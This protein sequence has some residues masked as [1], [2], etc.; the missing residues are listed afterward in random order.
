[1]MKW[2]VKLIRRVNPDAY[3]VTHCEHGVMFPSYECRECR[4]IVWQ[5]CEDFSRRERALLEHR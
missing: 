1:M 3:K 4:H 2:F 5:R